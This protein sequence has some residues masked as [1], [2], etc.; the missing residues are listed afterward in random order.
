MIH[1]RQ[2]KLRPQGGIIS[3]AVLRVSG[4]NEQGQR[5]IL[6]GCNGDSESAPAFWQRKQVCAISPWRKSE[7]AKKGGS[8]PISFRRSADF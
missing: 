8:Q 3:E 6:D 4:F 1:A 5:E 7:D 2:E